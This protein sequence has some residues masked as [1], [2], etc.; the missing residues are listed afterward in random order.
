VLNVYI[1][2]RRD[3]QVLT[4]HFIVRERWKLWSVAFRQNSFYSI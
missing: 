3:F 1:G 4:S 2:T